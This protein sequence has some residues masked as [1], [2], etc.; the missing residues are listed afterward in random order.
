MSNCPRVRLISS[1]YWLSFKLWNHLQQ[2]Q[3]LRR[4]VTAICWA[5]S[6]TVGSSHPFHWENAASCCWVL[7][8]SHTFHITHIIMNKKYIKYCSFKVA[9]IY[10]VSVPA[11]YQP[12]ELS[13]WHIVSVEGFYR[14]NRLEIS[15]KTSQQIC[16]RIKNHECHPITHHVQ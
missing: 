12:A 6:V 10:K 7:S 8:T 3:N 5:G 16:Q 14:T 1:Q 4:S 13:G 11:H 2:P 15:L 9:L